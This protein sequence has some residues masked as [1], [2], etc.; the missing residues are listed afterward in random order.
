MMTAGALA[1]AG[2]AVVEEEK[3]ELVTDA[4][5]EALESQ[6]AG[7]LDALLWFT[8]PVKLRATR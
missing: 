5:A 4:H 6:L 2:A 8:H 1:E 7:M 3:I